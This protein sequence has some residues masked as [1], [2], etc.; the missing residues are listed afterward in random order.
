MPNEKPRKVRMTLVGVNG[1]AFALMGAFAESARR[2]GWTQDEIKAVTKEAMSA[3]YD[4]LLRT[5]MAN[6]EEPDDDED[7]WEDD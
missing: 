1:N 6:I 4:H 5:L 7:E 3:N 2:Q